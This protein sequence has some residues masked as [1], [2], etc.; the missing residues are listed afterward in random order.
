[1]IEHYLKVTTTVA[2]LAFVFWLGGEYKKHSLA[3]ERRS[4][5]GQKTGD[6]VAVSFVFVVTIL[7]S[8]FMVKDI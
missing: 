2:V 8:L 6:K 4:G 7:V 3:N 5:Y 1:M